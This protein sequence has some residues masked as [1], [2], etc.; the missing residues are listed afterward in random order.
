MKAYI[1]SIAGVV[2][3]TAVITIIAPGGK[4]GKFL[5]GA[6]KLVILFVM[7]SP[8]AS[9]VTEGD[10]SFQ[11]ASIGMDEEY[12]AHCADRLALSDGA[13]IGSWLSEEYGVTADVQVSRLADETFSYE[14]IIVK[15]TDFGING[16]DEHIH[17]IEEVDRVLEER[18]GCDAEVA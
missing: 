12:L 17:I 13:A 2:L 6:T 15:I 5:K 14:K 10:L 8:L 11:T 18:Y 16:Q 9:W 4:M 1:L 7:V 3:L